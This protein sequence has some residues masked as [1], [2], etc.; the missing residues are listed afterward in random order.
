MRLVRLTAVGS[1]RC[2][3]RMPSPATIACR[4]LPDGTPDLQG[5]WTNATATPVERAPELGERRAFTEEEAEGD[6]QGGDRS[7]RSRRRAERSEQ[8]DRS[9]RVAAAGR[10]LQP[11]LDR[12]RHERRDH[13][14][15]V[16]HL[17]DHRAGERAHSR[18]CT[19]AGQQRIAAT[20]RAR[21]NDGPEGR[22]LGERC[23]LS[24]GS[25]SGPPML[26]VMYN[27]YYQIVQSPGYVMILVEMVHDARI[28]R[29]DDRAHAGDRAEVDGRS[30][31]HWEGDTLV[32]ET[33]NFRPEQSFRGSSRE[34]GRDRALHARRERQD[35]LSL[36]GRRSERRSPRRSRASCRS[37]PV[38]ANIYEYACHEGNYALPGILSGAR[39]ARESAHKSRVRE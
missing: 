19:A 26:P 5:V 6:Q 17:D 13:R 37:S 36:H 18:R 25:A 27:S 30:V 32:V 21:S 20:R 2:S 4:G 16:S 12:S 15:R 3:Q 14:R 1:S 34:H 29:I 9:D 23:L 22:A 31:G 39:E 24:F 35:R 33:R 10:Q 38:D 7:R 8:E 28:I 11:V